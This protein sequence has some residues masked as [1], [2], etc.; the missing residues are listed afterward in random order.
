MGV[1]MGVKKTKFQVID[2]RYKEVLFQSEDQQKC[3]DF[4][5]EM[6]EECS[7]TFVYSTIEERKEENE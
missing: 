5:D 7:T 2:T 3:V 4:M 6:W 1:K